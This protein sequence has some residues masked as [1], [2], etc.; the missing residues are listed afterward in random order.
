MAAPSPDNES[1]RLRALKEYGVLDTA[2]EQAFDDIT[3]LASFICKT[4]ISLISLIDDSR[5][6]FKARVGLEATQ[7]AR[8]HAFCA[9]AILKPSEIMVVPD[10]KADERFTANPL[11]TGDPH[12]RFYVGVPLVTPTG[13]AL[14]TLCVIDRTPRELDPEQ[15]EVLRAL[16]RQVIAQLELRRSL[17]TLEGAVGEQEQYVQRLED[18][19]RTMEQAQAQLES[20][21]AADGL[22]GLKNRRALDLRLEEELVRFQ[23]SGMPLALALLDV[24]K[25]KTYNDAFGHPAGDEVLRKMADILRQ[26]ARPYDFAARYGGEEFAVVLPGA[27][28][29]GALVIAERIRRSV[30]RAVWPNRPI[31]VS[32]G[33]AVAAPDISSSADLLS[34]ADKALYHSKESGRNRVSLSKDDGA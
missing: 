24:D 27:S 26:C 1:S 13:E 6:W 12:I 22:T 5:Q 8:E 30:H 31:T 14:G 25:F 19:Q 32:I 16:A 15:F 29:E 21:S 2:S 17:M 23:R 4:P 33:V 20:Q 10:A 28:R 9:H 7:T 11:V 34:R 3:Q 18:Y